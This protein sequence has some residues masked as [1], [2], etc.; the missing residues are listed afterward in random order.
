MTYSV[1]K[2]KAR[3]ILDPVVGL[4]AKLHI[5]PSALTITGFVVSCFAAYLFAFDFFRWAGVALIAASLFDAID[6]AVARKNDQVTDFGA[7]LDSTIDR[8]SEFAVFLGIFIHYVRIENW[9][10]VFVT[11]FALFGSGMVS[12]TRARAEG[13]GITCAVG[14]FDRTMR[15]TVIVIGALLGRFIF[16]YFLLLLAAFT[17]F[18]VIQRIIHVKK[19]LRQNE[20]RN[21][22]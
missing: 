13:L 6:G 12:Y 15:I 21:N 18:T 7:F 3:R 9:F 5:H 2:G 8:F 11:L 17:Q 20:R 4:F 1:L 22:A 14:F 16:G 19:A 10:L